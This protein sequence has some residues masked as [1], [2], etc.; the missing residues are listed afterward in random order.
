[1]GR[2]FLL[3]SLSCFPG[4]VHPGH[5]TARG[6]SATFQ[7][8]HTTP[9]RAPDPLQGV[10]GGA[11]KQGGK[12]SAEAALA[13]CALRSGAKSWGHGG[14]QDAKNSFQSGQEE[15][16]QLSGWGR[17]AITADVV[18]ILGVG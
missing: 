14:Q 1:M 2:A 9:G 18:E 6:Q 3:Q 12:S 15:A 10:G 4:Q 16:P 5:L 13:K 17:K 11:E 7:W 8:L